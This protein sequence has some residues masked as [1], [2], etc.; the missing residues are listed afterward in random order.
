[1][2]LAFF[3]FFHLLGCRFLVACSRLFSSVSVCLSVVASF[4]SL[5]P[6]LFRFLP[7]LPDFGLSFLGFPRLPGYPL[8]S[9]RVWCVGGAFPWLSW[10][11]SFMLV[12]R[13]S[14]RLC[15][16]GLTDVFRLCGLWSCRLSSRFVARCGLTDIFELS[17]SMVLPT[18]SSFLALWSCRTFR[19]F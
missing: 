3:C 2:L 17:G 8:V 9:L 14:V 5:F 10:V 7:R 11:L 12:S 16:F 1:M 6:Y 18:F 19:A 13:P 4:L 15:C